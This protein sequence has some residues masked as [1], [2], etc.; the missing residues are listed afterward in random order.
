MSFQVGGPA[1]TDPALKQAEAVSL[2]DYLPKDLEGAEGKKLKLDSFLLKDRTIKSISYQ[3][4]GA[5]ESCT[6]ITDKETISF[7]ETIKDGK[8]GIAMTHN[9]STFNMAVSGGIGNANLV[10]KNDGTGDGGLKGA[11]IAPGFA[12]AKLTTS[13]VAVTAS[14]K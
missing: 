9:G 6:I 10:L 11:N 3:K 2:R 4:A 8:Y 7:S 14:I 13:I 12:S 1:T 5:L